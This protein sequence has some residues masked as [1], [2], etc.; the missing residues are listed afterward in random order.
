MHSDPSTYYYTWIHWHFRH[1]LDEGYWPDRWALV[2]WPS[3]LAVL[4]FLKPLSWALSRLVRQDAMQALIFGEKEI[5]G[6][7]G[8]LFRFLYKGYDYMKVY[9]VDSFAV[10]FVNGQANW[11]PV[12]VERNPAV[13]RD[14]D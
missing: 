1:R 2:P 8:T 7:R 12:E 4:L 5:P 13:R 10:R 6:W 9:T 14:H 11:P 3:Y